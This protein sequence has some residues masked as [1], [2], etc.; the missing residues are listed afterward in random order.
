MHCLGS[1]ASWLACRRVI[2]SFA[3]STQPRGQSRSSRPD[4][5]CFLWAMS[6]FS[7]WALPRCIRLQLLLLNFL[8]LASAFS[9]ATVHPSRYGAMNKF[10]VINTKAD[11]HRRVGASRA[12]RTRTNIPLNVVTTRTR[13]KT[14]TPDIREVRTNLPPTLNSTAF[15][16]V[17]GAQPPRKFSPPSLKPQFRLW[18]VC[19]K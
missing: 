3:T 10:G 2:Q 16:D 4:Q 6:S 19:W 8:S 15:L 1:L 13:D 14:Q 17:L 18:L 7:L 12:T 11:V 9:F 5:G